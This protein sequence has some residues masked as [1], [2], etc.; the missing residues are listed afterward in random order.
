M[1][2]D[3]NTPDDAGMMP[4]VSSVRQHAAYPEREVRADGEASVRFP[5]HL[6]QLVAKAVGATQGALA[7]VSAEGD[8]REYFVFGMED[9]LELQRSSWSRELMRF[10]VHQGVAIKVSDFKR[11]LPAQGVPPLL[12]AQPPLSIGPFLGVPLTSYGRC[13][14]GLYLMRSPGE[15]PFSDQDLQTVLPV[16]AW[17]EPENFCEEGRLL[18]QFRLLNQVAQAAAGPLELPQILSIVL[19][20]LDRH[21]PQYTCVIW[22]LG[23]A[24]QEAMAE[25]QQ[26]GAPGETPSLLVLKS[27]G[28]IPNERATKLGLTPGLQLPLERTRFAACLRDGQ[29]QYVDFARP[30]QQAGDK[31]TLTVEDDL[32]SPFEIE[33]RQRGATSSFA[34][35]LRAGEQAVGMLHSICTRAA[36][37]TNEQI[38]LLYLVADLLGPAISNCQHVRRLRAAYEQLRTTH[39][40][41]LQAEKMRALGELAGGMAHDFNNSLCGV[42]GFLELALADKELDPTIGGY[43][44]SARTCTLDAAQ[45]V[46]RVQN[47][48][49]W[50]RN[51]LSIQ[52]LNFNELVRQTLELTRHKWENLAHARGIPITVQT[53]AEA[54][55]WIS[56]SAAELREVITNLVFNAVDAMPEGGQLNVTAW[57]SPTDIY[58]SVGDTGTGMSPSTR[59]RLFEPFFT[60]KGE[61]GNGL[62]LSVTFGIVQRYGGQITVESEL[63][64]GSCFTVR[65]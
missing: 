48:A 8:I 60:T 26:K 12:V 51:E 5:G 30:E 62:G 1:D 9:N 35:P 28:M 2:D 6:L 57:S 3:S 49:R 43:L 55:E 45:T 14:G 19:R 24:E 21:L 53:R 33:L 37:F 25:R 16:R 7:L 61:R 32:H 10:I 65:L 50:Q 38:Q 42:L 58:L 39:N 64:R 47:F 4:T 15:P 31:K 11:D 29:A 34:V 56:G 18:A 20:E 41:L 23:D 27:Y 17:L 59:R 54:K 40:Q 46:R 13:R 52:L 63:G 22:L 36:G 44:E